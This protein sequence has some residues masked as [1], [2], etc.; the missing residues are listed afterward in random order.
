MDGAGH[1]LLAGAALAQDQHRRIGGRHAV[2][3][4]QHL[5]HSRAAG[6]DALVA[7]LVELGAHDHVLAHQAGLLGRLADQ[8]VEL[9]DARRLGQVVVGAELHGLDR[10]GHLL[11]AGHDDDLWGLREILQLAQHLDALDVRH[12]HVEQ[13]HVGH[14]VLEMLEGGPAVGHAGRRVA[15]A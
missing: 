1:Q 14:L 7:R 10:G 4:A 9:L 11:E 13:Q 12:P 6:D 5:L 15:F 3:E 2:H 8:D